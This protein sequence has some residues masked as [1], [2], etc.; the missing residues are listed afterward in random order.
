[1]TKPFTQDSF[2][3][4]AFDGGVPLFINGEFRPG[5]GKP[6]DIVNPATGR[7]FAGVTD[8]SVEDVRSAVDAAAESHARGDWSGLSAKERAAVLNKF[9]E[10]IEENAEYLYHLETLNNGRPI[11]E[12]RAQLSILGDYYRYAAAAALTHR[13]A[14]IPS[15][16]DHLIS[17][18]RTSIGVCAIISPFNHPL[19][20]LSQSL[21]FALAAGNSVVVKPS[22][23]TPL[24]TLFLASLGAQ[25]G[26]PDGVLNVVAGGPDVAS[27]LISDDRVQKINFTGGER[28]GL[29]IGQQVADR[30]VRLTKELG[31]HSPILIFDDADLD[32]AVNGVCFASFIAAGQTCIAASR[33]VVHTA[34]YDEFV[35]RLVTKI[36]SLRLGDPA[37]MDTDLGPL[38]AA[39]RRDAVLQAITDGEAEGAVRLAGGTADVSVEGS[40]DGFYVSPVV[41]GSVSPEMEVAQREV[42]GPFVIV[43][44]FTDEAEAIS[45]AN[46]SRYALGA[47]VWTTD[48]SRAHWVAQR[49]DSGIC[50]INDHHRL[51]V[52][53]P[54][55]GHKASGSGKEAGIEGYEDFTNQRAI[56]VRTSSPSPDWY[57]G[58]S[59]RLN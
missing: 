8:A 52:S 36:G 5:G 21:P 7:P 30:H 18:Q 31:G 43:M 57:G 53:V 39:D 6:R 32:A 22:E 9:A 27:A 47:A 26:L 42:F 3:E 19:L 16:G 1:M 48:V 20:I 41:M 45:I 13:D 37:S 33:L 2:R 51:E 50:W 56:I 35:N 38:V 40:T 14:V 58:T 4:L 10:L 54:W 12:T 15:S 23:F 49:I 17:T 55:G 59:G 44:P 29:A 34:V 46:D 11:R 28:G 24:T 25:A